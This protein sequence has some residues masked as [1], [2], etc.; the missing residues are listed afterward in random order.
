[1]MVG[2]ENP[3]WSANANVKFTIR[4]YYDLLRF[5]KSKVNWDRIIWNSY[6]LPR[7]SFI[8]WLV[9]K[10]RLKTKQLLLKGHD[11]CW[12]LR[13]VYQYWKIYWS[14]I[15]S[16]PRIQPGLEFSLAKDGS[17]AYS[18]WVAEGMELDTKELQRQRHNLEISE[19]CSC[20][21]TLYGLEGTKHQDL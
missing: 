4:S 12:C 5:R 14:P 3:V 1:M 2:N 13:V 21:Y 9:V 11:Y 10:G 7:H 18:G 19:K 20:S 8:M 15:L 16:M 17:K 6:N